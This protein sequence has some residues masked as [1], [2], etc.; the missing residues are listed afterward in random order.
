MTGWI[1]GP[2]A[3]TELDAVLARARS[4]L[5]DA[6]AAADSVNARYTEIQGLQAIAYGK[7]AALRLDEIGSDGR[8]LLDAERRAQI[9]LS[10]HE[11][12]VAREAAD[13]ASAEAA[14]RAL[15]D[16]RKALAADHATAISAFEAKAAAT[17]AAL[18]E[19]PDYIALAEAAEEAKAV[20]ARAAQ[21]LKLAR[22]NRAEKGAP[23]E[24]DPLF[25]YLWKRKFRTPE[26]RKGPFIR[27][28]DGWVA[29][30]CGYDKAHL[31]Y[32]RLIELPE[33]IA[34]HVDYVE[35]LEEAAER[36][37]VAA[38][39]QAMAA[40]GLDSLKSAADSI[41]S[42]IAACDAELAEAELRHREMA[43]RHETALAA[44]SG[45]AAEA[46]RILAEGLAAASFPDL[47]VLVAETTTLEDDRIVDQLVRLRAEEMSLELEKSRL[48][49]RP[50]RE[51][52]RL[53]ALEALRRQFKEARF[54]SPYAIISSPVLREAIDTVGRDGDNVLRALKEISRSLRRVAPQAHPDFGGWHRID[55]LT[56]PEI[57]G[58]VLE[59]VVFE[60]RRW[61]K[62]RGGSWP[63]GGYGDGRR[64]SGPVFPSPPSRSKIPS[65]SASGG[66]RGR[67]GG[68][69]RTG[70]G[71]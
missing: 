48:S 17:E 47:R 10:Q 43:A 33:R 7:L 25:M 67:S 46:R 62:T 15:E 23:Y 5:A 56:L 38:E 27:F 64:S 37:L 34:E 28:L 39:A 50:R 20:T 4:A 52:E 41:K 63:G 49:D 3:L 13:L 45:P 22:E 58:E 68:G 19:D 35:T 31:N 12:F 24:A 21:K 6:L 1:S 9:L 53:A 69:F 55:T 16:K 11:A 44:E 2:E 51:R 66:R 32:A 59:E 8:P 29:S 42:K 14:I 40:A 57:L 60:G 36:R 54:D 30:L 18:K 70:G 65:R 26:Y 61:N 71:F